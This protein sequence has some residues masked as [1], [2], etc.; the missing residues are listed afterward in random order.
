[1]WERFKDYYKL[2]LWLIHV[3]VVPPIIIGQILRIPTGQYTIGQEGDWIGFFGNYSGG[4]IGG[5]VAYFI[6]KE[7]IKA[8]KEERES[9]AYS[10]VE[11]FLYDEMRYNLKTISEC[12]RIALER[13]ANGTLNETYSLGDL[14]FE[15]KDY[16]K[17][18][19]ELVKYDNKFVREAINFYRLLKK[20][21]E[22]K[23]VNIIPKSEA[24]EIYNE[25]MKWKER[26]D[27]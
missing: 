5:L 6:A 1:V 23:R 2:L 12:M 9:F 22:Y 19:F 27:T 13:Q 10:I 24:K 4:I 11:I 15:F 18:K 16:E 14:K 21:S 3:F 7:Q 26:L 20:L 25:V 17:I 8:D